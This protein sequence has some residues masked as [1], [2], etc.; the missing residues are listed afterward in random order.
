MLPVAISN[1]QPLRRSLPACTRSPFLHDG[2]RH[3]VFELHQ[4]VELRELIFR[5][6]AAVERAFVVEP[7][8][9]GHRVMQ[10]FREIRRMWQRLMGERCFHGTALGVAT[11]DDIA[12]LQDKHGKFHIADASD[13][14]PVDAPS[15][16]DGGIKLPTLRMTNRSPGSVETN[17]SGTT[18]LSE[19]V[20]NSAS[21]SCPLDKS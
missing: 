6:A 21:G 12:D 10:P 20:M 4:D 5:G 7:K 19:Q 17:R 1:H 14:S 3:Q 13:R 2:I 11:D 16:V 9:G 15:T 18:R 8:S